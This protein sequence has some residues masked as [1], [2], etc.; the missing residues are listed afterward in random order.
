MYSQGY[1]T[2]QS[3]TNYTQFGD[4]SGMQSREEWTL[5][6]ELSLGYSWKETGLIATWERLTNQ[7]QSKDA[8]S[9][10]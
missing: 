7:N 6:Q 5:E 9:R 10:T 1:S 8:F 3:N 4:A 2:R